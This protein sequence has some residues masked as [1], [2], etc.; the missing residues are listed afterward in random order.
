MTFMTF[1][2]WRPPPLLQCETS[3]TRLHTRHCQSSVPKGANSWSP[4]VAADD[5]RSALVLGTPAGCPCSVPPQNATYVTLSQLIVNYTAFVR[6]HTFALVL[7]SL[8]EPFADQ[9][10]L[11]EIS[12]FL[13]SARRFWAYFQYYSR[14][15]RLLRL[16]YLQTPNKQTK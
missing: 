7:L 10:E 2:S 16:L 1:I 9:E 5:S 15:G 8:E 6:P 11:S 13:P 14:T 4:H 12:T 3:F